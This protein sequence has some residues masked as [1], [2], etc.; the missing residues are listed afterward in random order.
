MARSLEEIDVTFRGFA[1][2]IDVRGDA[3]KQHFNSRLLAAR[4]QGAG[5]PRVDHTAINEAS[6]RAGEPSIADLTEFYAAFEQAQAQHS[7]NRSANFSRYVERVRAASLGTADSPIIDLG[8]GSG[9]WLERLREEGLFASGVDISLSAID[10]CLDE[11]HQVRREDILLHLKAQRDNSVGVITAFFVLEHVG[12]AVV[13]AVLQE[14]RRVLVPNGLLL[15]EA[16]DPR[17]AEYGSRAEA[18]LRQLIAPEL[19]KFALKYVGFS[20]VSVEMDETASDR[21][22][23]G[24]A[25]RAGGAL[26]RVGASQSY[27]VT[28]IKTA[29]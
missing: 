1:K 9:K 19:L 25:Q 18:P 24:A 13:L 11:G 20:E 12:M 28:A 16:P 14:V 4:L 15:V 17:N 22:S 5:A 21:A 2:E 7:E 6:G 26:S 23:E 27:S 3:L 10:S 8:C 29:E